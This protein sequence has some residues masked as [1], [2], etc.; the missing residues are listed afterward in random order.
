M[1]ESHGM[2]NLVLDVPPGLV[3]PSCPAVGAEGD[4]L[5]S[6]LSPDLAP[7]ALVAGCEAEHDFQLPFLCSP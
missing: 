5:S 7:T 6:S 3:I 2:E 4:E 1:K